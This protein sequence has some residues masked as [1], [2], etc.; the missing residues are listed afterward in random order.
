MA[1]DHLHLNDGH[2]LRSHIPTQQA[3]NGQ[4]IEDGADY[5]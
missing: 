4:I 5:A 3:R 2:P 1:Y